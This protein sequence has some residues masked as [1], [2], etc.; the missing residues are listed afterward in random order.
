MIAKLERT[1]SNAQQKMAQT[2]NP[3]CFIAFIGENTLKNWYKIFE[4]DF[5]IE[6]E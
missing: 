2:H 1:Q 6:V 5:V 3:T 4:I